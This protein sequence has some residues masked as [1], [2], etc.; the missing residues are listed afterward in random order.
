[1]PI[2]FVTKVP[3]LQVS[4][5]DG[6]AVLKNDSYWIE[7]D[8]GGGINNHLAWHK[9]L[10]GCLGVFYGHNELIEYALHGRRGLLWLLEVGLVDDGL[11][12]ES[13]LNYHFTAIVPFIKLIDLTVGIHHHL[14]DLGVGGGFRVTSSLRRAGN[15][16]IVPAKIH[17]E[18][19]EAEKWAKLTKQTVVFQR[20]L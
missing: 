3:G 19:I 15:Y 9:M 6:P 7:N 16:G 2:P 11:W 14:V 10:L 20:R 17:L 4:P 5:G 18:A 8:I 1:M 13:S 12:C